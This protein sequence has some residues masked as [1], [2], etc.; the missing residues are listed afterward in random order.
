MSTKPFRTTSGA[1]KSQAVSTSAARVQLPAGDGY[2][3]RVAT[4]YGNGV[5]LKFGDS[6][7]TATASDGGWDY[8][9]PGGVVEVLGF[10]A[11]DTHVSVLTASGSNT[12]YL[13][14]G[15]GI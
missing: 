3:L 6:T 4:D 11:T 8:Y 5:F 14:R 1:T 9:L 7:V 10:K 12:V 13:A 2:N 15:E